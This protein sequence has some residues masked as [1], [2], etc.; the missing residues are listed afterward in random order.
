MYLAKMRG[1]YTIKLTL[2]DEALELP[3]PHH[4]SVHLHL[5]QQDGEEELVLLIQSQRH[6]LEHHNGEVLDDAV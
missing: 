2:D 4:S 3:I 6:E 1:V 5:S